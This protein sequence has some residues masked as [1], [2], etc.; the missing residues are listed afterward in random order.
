MIGVLIAVVR[1]GR[2]RGTRITVRCYAE[3][4]YAEIDAASEQLFQSAR[5]HRRGTGLS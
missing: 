1:A 5:H 4:Q 2:E 3:R